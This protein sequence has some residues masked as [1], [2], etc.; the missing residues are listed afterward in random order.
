MTSYSVILHFNKAAQP[1][2]RFISDDEFGFKI[3]II[4]DL[5]KKYS[6]YP[7]NGPFDTGPFK[8][9]FNQGYVLIEFILVA[10]ALILLR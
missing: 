5:L 9:H 6:L 3:F 7:G 1:E 2:I 4:R 8:Q 10:L